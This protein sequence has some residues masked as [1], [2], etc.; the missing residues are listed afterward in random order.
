MIL[1]SDRGCAFAHRVLALLD[2]LERSADLRESLVG[3]TP[4]GLYQYSSS[5]QLPLLVHGDLVLMES[6]VMLEHLAEYCELEESYPADLG[7]R[8]R[9][10]HAM[11][12]VDGVLVPLLFGRTDVDTRRLNDVLRV[13]EVAFA[14]VAPR[15]C[16]LAFHVAPIWL[17]F[18]LWQPAHTV[19]YAI[20]ARANLCGWLDAAVQLVS[21]RRTAP[22]P[23]THD[24]DLIRARQAALL[25]SDTRR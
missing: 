13:L 1:F 4:A 5:G 25:P 19:T 22:D 15:A 6:R 18:R 14:T 16:L 21:L 2:H 8:S 24:E 12:V 17:R 20:Q 3:E 23:A 11:A 10:R 9:H 7:A